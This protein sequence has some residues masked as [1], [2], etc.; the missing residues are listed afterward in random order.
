M[1]SCHV[2][3]TDRFPHERSLLEWRKL[4]PGGNVNFT[5]PGGK[6]LFDSVMYCVKYL[7]KENVRNYSVMGKLLKK[8]ERTKGPCK[9]CV[10]QNPKLF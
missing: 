5:Y 2:I 7:L 4:V 10:S 6:E 9:I 1:V 8:L 3:F